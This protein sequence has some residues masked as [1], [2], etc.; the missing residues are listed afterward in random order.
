MNKYIKPALATIAALLG[1]LISVWA[2][3]EHYVPREV[4]NLYAAGI[5][6]Q[7]Q[8]I[9]KSRSIDNAYRDIQFWTQQ[10]ASL[11]IQLSKI[12]IG[13]DLY[14]E[15][16]R[17]LNEATKQKNESQRLLNQLRSK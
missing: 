13:T 6:D 1:L 16:V 5:A 12:A 7:F 17:Q 10:E 4:Y 14:K 15:L 2:I 3:D 11:R 9:T 8:Q